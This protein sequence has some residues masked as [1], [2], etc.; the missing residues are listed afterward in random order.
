[1]RLVTPRR[2]L[3]GST[4]YLWTSQRPILRFLQ[5]SGVQLPPFL[6]QNQWSSG[7]E[8]SGSSGLGVYTG[9]PK[10]RTGPS[11]SSP[12]AGQLLNQTQAYDQ[13]LVSCS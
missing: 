7:S 6:L 12:P 10:S 5:S 13:L 8:I 4:T 1:M 11:T 2:S 3:R 9:S